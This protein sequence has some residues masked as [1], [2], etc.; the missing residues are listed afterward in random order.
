MDEL[1]YALQLD[2]VELRRRNDTMVELATNR[3]Y[4]SR[5]LLR[6]IERGVELFGW[7]ERNPAIRS[8]GDAE[9][10]I[11]YG[12][13][14]AF[15]PTQI[16]PAHCRITLAL[17][18]D[19]AHT[20][21]RAIAE[22][23]THEIGTGIR[24]LVAMTVA[25]LLG[26]PLGDVEV[27]IGDSQLPAAPL[28]AGSNSTATIC[29][30]L[31]KCCEEI[32]ALL[33]KAAVKDRRSALYQCDPKLVRLIEGHAVFTH[34]PQAVGASHSQV[35]AEAPERTLGEPAALRGPAEPLGVAL[36]RVRRGKP[37][38]QRTTNTPHGL[39]PVIGPALVNKGKPI[40]MGGARLKDRMQFA[41]GA[42]FVEVRVSRTTGEV[43]VPRMVG[44]FAGGRIMNP[45]TA[46]AQL[47]G[48]QVW[49]LSSAMEATE[50]D[51]SLARYC[52]ADLAEYHVPVCRDVCDITTVMVEEEDTLVN[53]L[54][55]KGIGELG[56]T[57]LAAAIANAVFHATGVR[58][59]KLPIRLDKVLC[60]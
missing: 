37:L 54:G 39:P 41:H 18:S 5:S 55:V 9:E 48:G 22:V 29:N 12:F 6:C 25:D 60:A 8:M 28:S 20:R 10:F 19:G 23:G 35:S 51:P 13:A 45:R 52:N 2:P 58:I 11:G 40:M 34:D 14:A 15:Y 3:P 17:H 36:R 46:Y 33:A 27:R 56:T 47:Q 50:V 53:P 7:N 38:V 31:A 1:S 43:R 32:R 42:H 4:T 49:G 26:L 24:T 59:R 44:V 30:V 21:P 57:G 16:G